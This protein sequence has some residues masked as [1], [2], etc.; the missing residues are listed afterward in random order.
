M[1]LREPIEVA[2]FYI[3]SIEEFI[4]LGACALSHPR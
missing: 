3:Y 2:V 1:K 4:Y